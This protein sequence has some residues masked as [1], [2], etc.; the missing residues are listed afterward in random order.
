MNHSIHFYSSVV[1]SGKGAFD[2]FIQHE[3]LDGI[4]VILIGVGRIFSKEFIFSL[5]LKPSTLTVQEQKLHVVRSKTRLIYSI[6][7]SNILCALN[8]IESYS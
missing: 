1:G 8:Q 7:R 4:T 6:I 2:F 5:E 3:V